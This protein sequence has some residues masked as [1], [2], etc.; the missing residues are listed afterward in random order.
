MALC[1]GVLTYVFLLHLLMSLA[2][3]ALFCTIFWLDATLLFKYCCSYCCDNKLVLYR[4]VLLLNESVRV[5]VCVCVCVRVCTVLYSSLS[6]GVVA[7][8]WCILGARWSLRQGAPRRPVGWPREGRVLWTASRDCS[9]CAAPLCRRAPRACRCCAALRRRCTCRVGSC[10]VCTTSRS[11]PGGRAW[12]PQRGRKGRRHG[13]SG[14]SWPAGVI[15]RSI[16]RR[17]CLGR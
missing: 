15:E 10:P 17:F 14:H 2:C 6:A 1:A 13:G 9:R 5:C 3:G 4:I 7:T 16:A 12:P 8:R 11:S